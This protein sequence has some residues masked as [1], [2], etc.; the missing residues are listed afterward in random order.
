MKTIWLVLA[1]FLSLHCC[2]AEVHNLI[3]ARK[4]A[5]AIALLKAHPEL[6]ELK[7]DMQRTPLHMAACYGTA[8]MVKFLVNTGADLNTISYNK[9]TP[10]HVCHDPESATILV[11]A[12]AR[13]DLIDAW[14]NTAMQSLARNPN[15][16]AVC[17]A[18]IKAGVPLDVITALFLKRRDDVIKMVRQNP[19][20]VKQHSDA[21]TLWNNETPLGLAVANQ[22]FE[23][24]K[25]FVS[26]GAPVNGGTYMVNAGNVTTP[27]CTAIVL[28]DVNIARFLLENGAT[29]TG[30]AGKFYPNIVDFAVERSDRP[31]KDLLYRYIQD[32]RLMDKSMDKPKREI[33]AK[34]TVHA[35]GTLETSTTNK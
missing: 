35:P 32:P 26:L 5:E 28:G 8:N 27:L 19:E 10:L 17:E 30:A 18:M 24:V 20:L 25:L 34:A 1:L 16:H 21:M 23:M 14:G 3:K 6:L 33:E 12:E 15:Y 4:D 2:A 13:T 9:F 11:K 7:D 29:V 31:M 22:D